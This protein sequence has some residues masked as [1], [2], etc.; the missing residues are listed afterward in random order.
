M[1]E[2][3]WLVFAL[4]LEDNIISKFATFESQKTRGK[5]EMFVEHFWPA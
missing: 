2:R 5:M 4:V 1:G 3:E